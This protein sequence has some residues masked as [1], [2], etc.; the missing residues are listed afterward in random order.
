MN[1]EELDSFNLADAV[2]FH[3]QLNPRLWDQRENLRP[4]VQAKLMAIVKDFQEFLGVPDLEVKDVTVSGSNAA[5]NYTPHSD[6]DLHLVVDMP[7]ARNSEVFRE[8]FDA[9]K[10]QYNTEHD[11]RIG[12]Y[13]V[14]LY[15]QDSEQEHHSQGIYSLL[16]NKW[17]S[18]PRRRKP[19]ID[20]ISVKSKYE[21]V[22]HRIEAAILDGSIEQMD[23]VWDKLRVMRKQGLE[24]EGEFAPENLVFKMLRNNGTIGNLKQA[25]QAVR[26][27]ELSLAEAG[28]KKSKKK[29]RYGFGGYWTPGY[30]FGDSGSEGGGNGGGGESRFMESPDGVNPSTK[31]F[32]EDDDTE[33]FVTEFIFTTADELGIKKLPGVHMHKDDDWSRENNSF[34]RYDP[35]THDLH[36]SLVNRHPL[37]IMRTIAHEL[38]HC[39]QHEIDPV[40]PGD[41][42]TGSD[43]EN[44]AHAVAGIV[45]RNFA[46]SHPEYFERPAVSESSGYIPTRAQ[47]KDPRYKM[48]LT[49]D[50]KPGQTGREANKLAL[51]TDAQGRPPLLMKTANLREGRMPQPSQGSGKTQDLNEPL[52]PETPPTMPAGTVRVDVS[53]VYD[54]Y[55]LG[56]HISNMKG[57]GKHDFGAGPPSSII[58]FGDEETEHKFIQDLEATGLDV[59]DIDPRDPAQP[60]GM[61][62]IKTD[63]TY[64]V[65]EGKMAELDIDLEDPE[66]S[67]R[68]FEKM[69]G[70]TRKEARELFSRTNMWDFPEIRDPNRPL[71]EQGVAEGSLNEYRDRLLQYVKSLLPTWPEYV[72]KDWLV[73]NKGDF[74]NLPDTELKNGIMEKLKGAGL[75]PNSKWQLVPDMKFTMDM[76]DPK[77][78]QLLAGRAGGTSDLGMGIPK[79]KER[80]ATQA[81]L[82]Q[83][84]G[85]VRKEPVL[86]IK[87][88][89]GY[90][91]LEGWH[92]TIQHFHKFPDGYTGPA[93]VA[94]AQGQQGVAEDDLVESLRQELGLFEDDLFE[95][96]MTSKNLA[97]LAQDISGA[98]VG[99]E[100]EMIVPGM[101]SDDVEREPDYDQDQR[102]TD[103]D[104]AITFFDDGDYNSRH[105]LT[106]LREAMLQ[107]YYEWQGEISSQDWA[108]N[109]FDYFVE[110]LDREDPFDQD[111]AEEEIRNDLQ[112]QYG[113]ELELED[114]EKML[115]AAIQE[116]RL[117]YYQEQWD[118]Q[119][120]NYEYAQEEFNQENQDQYSE[121][122]WFNSLGIRTAQDVETT[123]AGYV[124]WP[125]W[126]SS[127]NE[128]DMKKIALDFMNTMGYD[129]IAVGNYHG[130]GGGYELWNGDR[131]VKIGDNKP[132]DAF[133]VET[134]GSLEGDNMGDTGL[135][136]VSP[137]IPLEQI[138]D[139]MQ[140]VQAWAGLN[141]VYTGK[142]N[143]TSMHTNISVPGYDLDKLDYLKAALLLGDEYVLR[144]FGRIGNTYAKPAI[145][146][147]KELIQQRPEKAQEL[148]DKMK[149]QLNAEASKL[150][151][152]GQTEK[153]TSINTKDNRIEFRSPGG[154]Y[155]S[156]I[157]DNPQ[158]MIDTIN[159]MV[160]TMDAALDPNKYKQEYQKKLYKVLTGQAGGREAGTGAKQEIKTSDKDLLNLFSRYAA[161]ELPRQALK[162][163]VRQAQL[164]RSV[165]KGKQTGK[166]WWRVSNPPYSNASIEVVASSKKEAI[167]KAL[168]A[169][170]YPGWAN[171]QQSVVA[172]PVR[173]YKE[174]PAQETL[175]WYDVRDNSG[176]TM[177]FQARNPTAAMQAAREQYPR[178]F[179][180]IVDVVLN[181]QA[182]RA[183]AAPRDVSASGEVTGPWGRW[184]I[185]N[186]AGNAVGYVSARNQIEADRA[187]GEY[188]LNLNPSIN[189]AEFTVSAE[190]TSS[191]DAAQGGLIDVPIEIPD[192]APRTLTTPGQ[193]QQQFTGEWKVVDSEGN[194][195]YRFGGVGNAQSDA[196]RVA[197][198]WLRQNPGR[199]Q[200]GVTVVPV[201]R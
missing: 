149:S 14:E 33:S 201:M 121:R 139:T 178:K 32:L 132:L 40:K 23:A 85:G 98:Q 29:F 200:A 155:L 159:R 142:V 101:D 123:F 158:K 86:L 141:G 151:H 170:G 148:L 25:R 165:A 183:S 188:L 37:D 43:V 169:D 166:M 144:E 114:F 8:L 50:V 24:R 126:T 115:N 109:G 52:G 1:I 97:K 176:Y 187:A 89:K 143:K 35:D 167:E 6:V 75:T 11:I 65:A 186:A 127:D 104:D 133:T 53:D 18:V 192:I 45:M 146:K 92:R 171:T 63:P 34:G 125:Y 61:R 78:K 173:P 91:L 184:I 68:Q 62:P 79:D 69:Y 90:E 179:P 77:T 82:A 168:E 197:M 163:F 107:D 102:V 99:L 81:A 193:P 182:T 80:H 5:Y 134:D 7:Q 95:V 3:D 154:D 21:D 83:Q 74:S 48:A 157:A 111:A 73:P 58:S 9:K 130:Y 106:A 135:E 103:I 93:Y 60:R 112:T 129:T 150:I 17:L 72:L 120:S 189:T 110:Y 84:Q 55:K 70:M 153:F 180:N 64:N 44:E 67:D 118:D 152:S 128:V 10:F 20:D 164:E 59:T 108:D 138:G 4:E 41:G 51:D 175:N 76:W 94:V 54:W 27:R 147:V 28:K 191:T 119:G 88:A 161:G 198:N 145:N 96:K 100:F 46:N 177:T 56:Q 122:D 49:V 181:D 194:E 36:V 31:M 195:I 113:N 136:F 199:M 71:H 116:R 131:W 156:D 196:N 57:L 38:A 26:D 117:A 190:T 12:G 172:E 185:S 105:E 22:G 66:I 174:E 13:D 2:K 162:S 87:I 19:D 15:V 39:R 160:V 47:A 124:N 140:K 30:S 137:P 42:A 16:Q